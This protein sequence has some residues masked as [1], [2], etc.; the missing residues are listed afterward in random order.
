MT[1]TVLLFA[2]LRESKGTDR[3]DVELRPGETAHALFDRLFVDRPH[4]RWPGALLFAVNREYVDRGHALQDG[5]EVAFVPPLGGGEGEDGR[6][7]LHHE[8]IPEAEVVARVAGPDKGGLCVFTGWVRDHHA[9]RAVTRLEYEAYEPMAV[10]EMSRICDAVAL[11]WPGVDAAIA[12]RL[13]RLEI[14]DAA[15]VIAC[16][17]AHRAAAFEACRFAIDTLKE[18]VPIF[19]KEF[20][21]DGS[22]WKGQG[23]G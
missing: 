8:R 16:A 10:Q 23:G 17:S 3:L 5:D 14:G 12:H 15:V 6:V 1:V 13:G 19:K 9:G 7:S 22:V 21:E 4:P 2:A 11:R 18:T 20:Y